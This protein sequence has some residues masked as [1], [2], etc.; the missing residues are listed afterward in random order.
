MTK[1]TDAVEAVAGAY[2][3]L[4]VLP[5]EP[6]EAETSLAATEHAL[7]ASGCTAGQ[8]DGTDGRCVCAPTREDDGDVRSDD[9]RRV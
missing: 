8:L 7:C 6:S 2:Y 5:A 3:V 1:C 4:H 9:R